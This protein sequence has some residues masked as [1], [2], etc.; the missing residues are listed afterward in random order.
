MSVSA[1][2]VELLEEVG[3]QPP[4][5]APESKPGEVASGEVRPT[6]QKVL[7]TFLMGLLLCLL[8]MTWDFLPSRNWLPMPLS[9]LVFLAFLIVQFLVIEGGF[10]K[11]NA[12]SVALGQ[13]LTETEL[14]LLEAAE[15]YSRFVPE[16]FL[17]HLNRKSI[18]QVRLGDQVARGMTVM[19]AD[20]RN[21]TSMSETMS[22]EENFRMLNDYLG[23]IGPIIREQFGFI[24]KYIGDAIMAFW[25][26]PVP[27]ENHATRGVTAA[28]K[29]QQGLKVLKTEF[30]K[31]GWPSIAVGVGLSS[32]EMTVG[33]MGSKVR[34]AY[35]VMGDTVNLGSRLEGI[36]RQYGVAL[37]V[38]QETARLAQGIVFR[39]ID[40]VRV[41]G[42]DIPIQIYEPLALMSEAD[43]TTLAQLKTWEQALA[44]YRAQ[45]WDEAE[46]L[47][48]KLKDVEPDVRLYD[49]F[50]QRVADYR[51]DP[52]GADWDGVKKFDSK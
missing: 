32:G 4:A 6:N 48:K 25:G 35:T 3:S 45:Q 24:D 43:A 49:I 16:Q 7:P 23:H 29:M 5:L 30:E 17:R 50:L 13:K 2:P 10:R 18:S 47:L 19:F 11:A 52:P 37:L 21:F 9:P 8:A 20:I 12:Q 31:K 28:L 39:E 26:A 36:T 34:K 42:K 40:F 46:T 1:E 27:D 44:A 15:A 41:K 33:D 22:P 14:A 51:L 38:S